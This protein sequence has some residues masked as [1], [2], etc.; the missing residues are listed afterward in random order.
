[1]KKRF[2]IYIALAA[3][4]ALAISAQAAV[5]SLG[6]DSSGTDA[7]SSFL[8]KNEETGDLVSVGD[9]KKY[10]SEC[11][12]DTVSSCTAPLELAGVVD[13]Y[14]DCFQRCECPDGYVQLGAGQVAKP[15]STACNEGN[16][17]GGGDEFLEDDIVCD[18]G[19]Q[20]IAGSNACEKCPVGTYKDTQGDSACLA[21]TGCGYSDEAGLSTCKQCSGTVDSNT[22]GQNIGCS[23][24]ACPANSLR[25]PNPSGSGIFIANCDAHMSVD[26][27]YPSGAIGCN[28]ADCYSCTKCAE[29]YILDLD[30]LNDDIQCVK[31]DGCIYDCQSGYKTQTIAN[32]KT[33]K[34]QTVDGT[35]ASSSCA[36]A[37]TSNPAKCYKCDECAYGYFLNSAG[38]CQELI[39]QEGS[40]IKPTCPTGQIA[41]EVAK[42]S[43]GV[44]SC[45]SSTC[46]NDP[47]AT[48]SVMYPGSSQSAPTCSTGMI[49][50]V[51][52]TLPS[53]T[54]CYAATCIS[55]PNATCAVMYPGSSES[56]PSCSAGY[57]IAGYAKSNPCYK[58]GS[59]CSFTCPMDYG[60]VDI[61]NCKSFSYK[62][63]NYISPC[64]GGTSNAPCKKCLACNDGYTLVGGRCEG[65]SC[66][67]I[68]SCLTTAPSNATLSGSICAD[69]DG[70]FGQTGYT[71]NEGYKASNGACIA[72]TCSELYS[73]SS[74]A[75][76]CAT[77]KYGKEVGKTASG[78][79]CYTCTNC[80]AQTAG[81]S[82][83]PN[84]TNPGCNATSTT[85]AQYKEVGC[86]GA[87]QTWWSDAKCAS[88]ESCVDNVCKV[89]VT[90]P[91]GYS[92]SRPSCAAGTY[93]TSKVENGLTCYT[94]SKC[95]LTC[96]NSS[97]AGSLMSSSIY[98]SGYS[99]WYRC[100][101]PDYNRCE[102]YYTYQPNYS[103]TS[104][105]GNYAGSDWVCAYC[106]SPC[107]DNP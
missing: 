90:C 53:G 59:G 70:N 80:T 61:S 82:G 79:K 10:S 42:A 97:F 92:T 44:T 55:D 101:A 74:T 50:N 1:M 45:Y 56:V 83:F 31:A 102:K 106:S 69:C 65:K 27:T 63:G 54:K 16:I 76:T 67:G 89:S 95:S 87:D 19:Y 3:L 107:P 23:E 104:K 13:N 51:V 38:D 81:P 29:G 20:P 71:C 41:S 52:G 30:N 94:C 6:G 49:A 33:D 28:V 14:E 91:T 46:T 22:Q 58:C 57:I 48:C 78:S 9:I 98:N 62:S 40:L 32:C 88:N 24:V 47:N 99:D 11:P 43:D 93:E 73:G 15:G 25:D 86:G 39:C 17:P 36:A 100:G 103:N 105:C 96:S 7:A 35:Y 8:E 21:C 60:L 34:L 26:I 77:G 12:S 5:I 84:K 37:N 75:S 66:I 64:M 2:Y 85:Q 68:E 4:C 18:S 72:K